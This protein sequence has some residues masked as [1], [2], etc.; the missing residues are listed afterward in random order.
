[1]ASVFITI[2]QV[3]WLEL[4]WLLLAR[5]LALLVQSL[6]PMALYLPDVNSLY[7]MLITQYAIHLL[8]QVHP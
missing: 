8:K 4:R 5:L 1:M 3:I 2:I 7:P 6:K